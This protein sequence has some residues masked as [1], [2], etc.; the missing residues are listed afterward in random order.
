M[1]SLQGIFAPV[2]G[3]SVF[4]IVMGI[5]IGNFTDFPAAFY[6]GLDYSSKKILKIA[7]VLVG[8]GLSFSQVLVTGADTFFLMAFTIAAAFLAAFGFGRIMGIS[9][10]LKSLIGVG[11][12]ICGGSAIAAIAPIIDAED[13][14]ISYSISTVFLFNIA[15]VFVFPPLGHL[16]GFTDHG[17]GL[18]AGTAINDTS[19]VV[20][21]GY[22]FSSTAGDLATIVKLTRTTMIVPIALVFAA[23]VSVRSKKMTSSGE[24]FSFVKIFPWFVLGFCAMSMLNSLNIV[25]VQIMAMLKNTG[26]FMI[27]MHSLQSDSKQIFGR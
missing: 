13:K 16:L 7:I 10:S 5:L 25:P 24:R 1:Q 12:A 17:F 21:A 15:A 19:S 3:A 4:G 22:T 23:I 20:A 27:V 8:A 11:T 2:I 18:W 14:D 6:P 9:S 26:R